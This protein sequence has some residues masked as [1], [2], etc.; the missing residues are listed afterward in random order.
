MIVS[1]DGN[2]TG[3]WLI[4]A[5]KAVREERRN[6]KVDWRGKY[7]QCLHTII[8]II[9]RQAGFDDL[10][11]EREPEREL[12]MRI[13]VCSRVVCVRISDCVSLCVYLVKA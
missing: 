3:R 4:Q 13:S 11:R 5:S 12:E 10:T 6:E 2:V 9:K 7:L 8:N 1:I